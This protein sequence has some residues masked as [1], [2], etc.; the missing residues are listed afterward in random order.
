MSGYEEILRRSVM[1]TKIFVNLPVEDLERS[2]RFF[3]G[4]GF[5]FNPQFTDHNAACL[6]ISDDIYA[7]LLVKPFFQTFT[8]KPI[9]DSTRT[10]EVLVALSADS[11][12]AV[13]AMLTKA[14]AAGAEEAR[15]PQ[16]HGFMYGRSFEDPD[17]HIWEIVWMDPAAVQQ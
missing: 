15:E 8:K 11:R 14:L 12:A 1:A 10:T 9:A 13:D 5:D 7:M 2:K 3:A 16:D 6:V 17:G 4:L